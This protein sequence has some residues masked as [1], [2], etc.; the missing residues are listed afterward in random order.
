MCLGWNPMRVAFNLFLGLATVG[1]AVL[2]QG[3]F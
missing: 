2:G 1:V 3:R